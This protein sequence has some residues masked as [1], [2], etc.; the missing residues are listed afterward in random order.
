MR[1]KLVACAVNVLYVA[2]GLW[3]LLAW[4]SIV[5]DAVTF[6]NQFSFG[7]SGWGFLRFRT[8][9]WVLSLWLLVTIIFLSA[10]RNRL[11]VMWVW[12]RLIVSL[13]EI[14]LS[15]LLV[16]LATFLALGEVR[17]LVHPAPG[18]LV[19]VLVPLVWWWLP[20]ALA[21]SGPKA[22]GL[23]FDGRAELVERI[24][25]TVSQVLALLLLALVATLWVNLADI[26]QKRVGE[27]RQYRQTVSTQA[28]ERFAAAE[29]LLKAGGSENLMRRLGGIYSLERIASTPEDHRRAMDVLAAYVRQNAPR[30][31]KDGSEA[32]NAS[33]LAPDIQ[34]TLTVIG[35]SVPWHADPEGCL[36]LRSTDLRV[37]KLPEANLSRSLLSGTDLSFSELRAADLRKT[38][39]ASALLHKADLRNV[40]LVE[41]DLRGA[42][43]SGADLTYSF[44]IEA[45]LSGSDLSGANLTDLRLMDARLP[46]ARL[47]RARLT[48]ASVERVI[49]IEADLSGA[50]LSESLLNDSDL[51]GANLSGANLR[52]AYL[53]KVTLR[54]ADL[55]G[56]N[57]SGASGLTQEQL[58]TAITDTK[59]RL[60]PPLVARGSGSSAPGQR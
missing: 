36:D 27:A 38:N 44:L 14:L 31:G 25:G 22:A 7:G 28:P 32:A 55:R 13:P 18:V 26:R 54:G 51:T 16:V 49:A 9:L 3:L 19:L 17:A 24:R 23:T 42:D 33:P 47:R 48:S 5:P 20:R 59:T 8:G 40:D 60:D 46:G 43:L 12:P 58:D 2:F 35:R 39:L 11:P 34:A 41:A 10:C 4:L 29:A 15:V 53:H 6:G 45:N 57:L 50:D 37:A 1:A 52:D 56:A 21:A 30:Q